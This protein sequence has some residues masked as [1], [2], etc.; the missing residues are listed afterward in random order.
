MAAG[1]DRQ[2]LLESVNQQM[3][4]DVACAMIADVALP[5]EDRSRSRAATSLPLHTRQT[6]ALAS[7]A[8]QAVGA[9]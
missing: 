8:S 4:L 5:V 7:M 3:E 9:P 2:R 1:F 6:E